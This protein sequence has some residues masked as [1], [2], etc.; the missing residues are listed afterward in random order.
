MKRYELKKNTVEIKKEDVTQGCVVDDTNANPK[1][2]KSFDSKE[3]ALNELKKYKTDVYEFSSP[4]GTMCNV[5]E[6][7]VEEN[8]YDE[9]DE[10]LSGGDVWGVSEIE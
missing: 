2:I 5:T 10:W 8:E 1:L 9:D 7:Y 6:Y 4:I 3:E